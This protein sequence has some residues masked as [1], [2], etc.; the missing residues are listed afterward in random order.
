MCLQPS[1]P[2]LRETGDP[3]TART[4]P[5][6]PFMVHLDVHSVQHLLLLLYLT[7]LSVYSL[8]V[9][10][11]LLPITLCVPYCLSLYPF[12]VCVHVSVLSSVIFSSSPIYLQKKIILQ[13]MLN[14]M[15]IHLFP[16]PI[17]FHHH[18]HHHAVYLLPFSNSHS[19]V[20]YQKRVL[21]GCE[22]AYEPVPW[23]TVVWTCGGWG[24]M[25]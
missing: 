1:A 10:V 9:C 14:S 7:P 4:F 6:K 2:N 18:H 8:C 25:M 22:R 3:E 5:P 19:K 23:V 17:T 13:N 21:R 11:C 15:A 24:E 16:S 12:T 20:A